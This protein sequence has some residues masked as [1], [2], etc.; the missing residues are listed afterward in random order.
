V[1]V[2]NPYPCGHAPRSADLARAVSDA[3]WLALRDRDGTL[4]SER[5]VDRDLAARLQIREEGRPFDQQ[6]CSPHAIELCSA[7]ERTRIDL[8]EDGSVRAPAWNG[9]AE[10]EAP[11]ALFAWLAAAGLGEPLELWDAQHGAG[12][13]RARAVWRTAIPAPLRAG[14]NVAHETLVDETFLGSERTRALVEAL[15]SSEAAIV[16]LLDWYGAGE[17]A[18]ARRPQYESLPRLFLAGFGYDP[19]IAAFALLAAERA[20]AGAARFVLDAAPLPPVLAAPVMRLDETT[21][22]ALVATARAVFGEADAARLAPELER[23]DPVAPAG[24]TLVGFSATARLRR[25]V[26]DAERVWAIDGQELVRLARGVR[27]VVTFVPREAPLAA[28][29]GA[30]L[31]DR[32]GPVLRYAADGRLLDPLRAATEEESRRARATIAGWRVEAPGELVAVAPHTE[33][34]EA[35]EAFAHLGIGP[36]AVAAWVG[37]AFLDR[38]GEALVLDG[39]RIRLPGRPLAATADGPRLVVAVEAAGGVTLVGHDPDGRQ[40]VSPVLGVRPGDLKRLLAVP[41]RIL[42]LL[43]TGRGELVCALDAPGG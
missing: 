7:S 21:R 9:W 13:E 30:I 15:G 37:R 42:L 41:G 1:R 39:A 43:D 28:L 10:L 6:L 34:G 20:R 5:R 2:V 31:V 23:G 8:M 3:E 38:E 11:R 36:P 32:G 33:E 19:V 16:A 25:I 17:G 18:L 40:A 24:T 14:W 27:R 26:A 35:F 22:R 4:V 29:G 12:A